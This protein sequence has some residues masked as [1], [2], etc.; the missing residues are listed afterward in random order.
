MK[1]RATDEKYPVYIVYTRRTFRQRFNEH[2]DR[3]IINSFFGHIFPKNFNQDECDLY[4]F[5]YT[6][7]PIPA[8][9]YESVFLY[10]FDFPRNVEENGTTR[11]TFDLSRT[12]DLAASTGFFK[13]KYKDIQ[14]SVNHFEQDINAVIQLHL[15]SK[16]KKEKEW[17][18]KSNKTPK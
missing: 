10:T 16:A 12:Y 4:V 1:R 2:A 18:K 7:G 3:G 11:D 8:K 6:C 17:E 13:L 9:L 14:A 15:K 5:Q